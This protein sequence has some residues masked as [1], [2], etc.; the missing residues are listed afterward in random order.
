MS[1]TI[2]NRVVEMQFDN[3]HFETN[4]S[5]SL[6]TLDKLKKSLNLSGASKG[7]ENISSAA[8]KFDMSPMGNAVEGVRLRFSALEVMAVTALANITNSAV[9]AGKRIVSALTID[10]IKT[11][12]Q[13]YETQINAVQTILANTEHKG[14]T[15]DQVNQALDELNTYADK[16]I[17]NFTQMTRNIGTFT[18]AGV[19]LDKSVMSIKGIANLA[20]VS[21]S[22]SQ[23]AS[24]AMYQLS[25]ALAA[26]KV[27]L[28][29]W[30]SVVN[31]GMGGQVFQ[32]ALKRTAKRLG[33]NVDEM[34]AKYGSFRESLTQGEWL[35]AEVLT[36]TLSQLA[37]AYTKAD[38][39]QQ[40]Y[41][42]S[43][44]DEILKLAETAENAATKV[45]TFTQLIDT[46]KESLQSGWT[47]TWELIVG[48]FEQAKEL[49]TGV[50][51]TLGEMINRSSESR[52]D[53]LKGAL[54]SNWDKM[55][56]RINKAGISTK[57]FE[58]RVRNV[59]K[60]KGKDLDSLIEKYGSLE[61]AFRSGAITSDILKEAVGKTNKTIKEADFS[62]V[63]KVLKGKDK[64]DAVKQVEAALESLGY[65]LTGK[66]GKYYG[67]DGYFGTLT[68]DAVRAFQQAQGLKVTGIVDEETL[69]AL[70]EATSKTDEMSTNIDDIID[71]VDK[72]GGRELLIESFKNVFG[73]LIDVGSL[74]ASTFRS[75]FPK[76]TSEQLY[77]LIEKFKNL[78]DKFK[79][80]DGVS[81]KLRLTFRGLFA[82]LDVIGKVIGTV[83]GAG[84]KVLSKVLGVVGNSLLDVTS[85]IGAA[86]IRFRAWLLSNDRLIK[87]FK[88]F[89]N[90][91]KLVA[92]A[93]KKW[94]KSFIE[95]P[96]VQ[97]AIETLQNRFKKFFDDTKNYFKEGGARIADFIKRLMSM[98]SI[99]IDDLSAIFE[100]FKTNVLDYFI[101]FDGE[102]LFNNIKNSVTEFKNVSSKALDAAGEKFNGVKEKLFAFVDFIRSKIPAAIAILM[103][104]M[105]IKGI[106]KIGKILEAFGAPLEALSDVIKN[107]G[108][109]ITKFI[110]AKAFN[111]RTEGIKNLAISI[112]ILAASLVA[113]TFVDQ[114]K[115]WS[116]VGALGVLALALVGLSVVASKVGGFADFTKTSVSLITLSGA[117]FI[118]AQ[119]LKTMAKLDTG[120]ALANSLI[121]IV[122]AGALVAIVTVMSKFAPQ[123]STGS[124]TFVTLALA[125]GIMVNALKKLDKLKLDNVGMSMTILAGLVAALGILAM[126]CNGVPLGSLV[127]VIALAIG[128]NMMVG[129]LKKIAKIDME[130]IKNNLGAFVAVFGSLAIVM[131]LAK[132]FGGT[133]FSS[134]VAILAIAASLTL[135]TGVVKRL[136]EMDKSLIK[137]ALSV[138][139]PLLLVLSG[140]MLLMSFGAGGGASIG[141]SLALLSMSAAIVILTGAIMLL[142][143]VDPLGM[144]NALKAIMKLILCFSLVIA[145]SGLA[146]KATGTIIALTVSIG[147]LS[148]ALAGLSYIGQTNPQ[149]LDAATQA[150]G[151][152]I[153]MFAVLVAASALVSGGMGTLIVLTIAVGVLGTMLYI[154][155][156]LPVEQ[157]LGI[158]SSLSILLLSLA[159]SCAILSLINPGTALSGVLGLGTFLLGL[160]GI[161]AI[162]ATLNAAVPELQSFLESGLPLIETLG[163][164]LGSFLGGIVGGLAEGVTSS[165]PQIGTDL[166]TFMTNLEPFI[167]GAKTIDESVGTAIST[168]VSAVTSLAGAEFISGLTTKLFG[169]NDMS[170]FA[171]DFENLGDGLSKFATKTANVDPEQVSKASTAISNLASAASSMPNEGGWLAKIVGDNNMGTFASDLESL[172]D[173]LSKFA[174]KTATVN[175]DQV[176]KAATAIS[177]L[178]NAST[179]IPNE[180]GWVGRFMGENDAAVFGTK[181][182][183][184][185]DGISKF[186]DKVANVNGDNVTNAASAIS[187]LVDVA[188]K[189]PNQGGWISKIFGDNDMSTFATNIEELGTGL[190]AFG[191]SMANVTMETVTSGINMVSRLV[192]LSNLLPDGEQIT[193]TEFGKDIKKL[194]G[195]ISDFYTDVSDIDSV[196]IGVAVSA[197]NR[198]STMASGLPEGGYSTLGTF[199]TQLKS[200][201]TQFGAFASNIEGID[202]VGLSLAVDSLSGLITTLSNVA[203]SDFASLSTFGTTLGQIGTDGVTKFIQAF[204]D[205]N[206]KAKEA[207]KKLVNAVIDGFKQRKSAME[208]TAKTVASS[209]VSGVR[210]KYDSFKSAGEYIGKGLVQGLKSMQD[211]VAAAAKALGDTAA[212]ATAAAAQIKSPSRVFRRLGEYMGEGLVIGI[213]NYNTK[214][215]NAGREVAN[216]AIDGLSKNIT[217][218]SDVINSDI[219]SQPTIRPVMDLSDITAGARTIN[220]M[221]GM[222]PS[223]SA[224]ANVGAISTMMNGNQNG[225]N[226][227]VITAIKNLGQKLGNSSGDT[228]NING[229]TYDEGSSVANA[230]KSLVRAVVVERRT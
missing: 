1:T 121:L 123:L 40:G 191:T 216:S 174:T 103:G 24:T 71:G 92:T 215:Y 203:G 137:R 77:G 205:A 223:V 64:G 30:N 217:K 164:T 177:D 165:L 23:Q 2:E 146:G 88:A 186:S 31:A 6:S 21:G 68:E 151:K 15:L 70:K 7:L 212:D 94:I 213:N 167:T 122:L 129:T 20:A 149:G 141:A 192:N 194:G 184:L 53:L 62:L 118:L 108:T 148:I 144:D 190:A 101:N 206:T 114:K 102:K 127:G 208:S 107:I 204:T 47:Q 52:N 13:E 154:L 207:G 41:S 18:A 28:M 8:K 226:N 36:E 155:S 37:G 222:T 220:G 135:I 198:L 156:G 32:N 166:A 45:K 55:I 22:T 96:E 116:A 90:I 56:E 48:D 93:V 173:G 188:N 175:G 170:Q 179:N 17:Y 171:T 133:S 211:D 219:D 125:I 89:I 87:G 138:I 79:L 34:I 61:K 110:N 130:S 84:L 180:G 78:T 176:S 152:V 86:A 145:V 197:A 3:K 172:G 143:K 106:S 229:V 43:Q 4:V 169:D 196:T 72:L 49:W 214:S 142:A 73:T 5:T 221:F 195:Y 12:L 136:G 112:G 147:I 187:S 228:Y 27:S 227:D 117:L 81:S 33:H 225:S 157:T 65:V 10:P 100:D 131:G 19:D 76:M 200:F 54:T 109:S 74:V 42:A 159:A 150:L 95:L 14:T 51:D 82:I 201:G 134:G 181:L 44:A 120:K 60:D 63:D 202:A 69:N 199:G 168:L 209:G 111:E 38:L 218:I 178:A 104:F 193:L 160:A 85:K 57:D 210:S 105:A 230:V 11:G 39:M 66:D 153:L 124:L 9:N 115:L 46:L 183:T 113:L 50:S 139:A 75:I 25:Q 80:T 158:A 162:A 99:T 97:K 26:G 163:N 67:D 126:A 182:E 16:T 91:I 29:D 58:E 140:V 83:V 128:V 59:A 161:L 189:I 35:T 119:C 185:G 132:L 98:D 224:L